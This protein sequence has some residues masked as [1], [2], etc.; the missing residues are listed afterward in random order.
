M[1]HARK[2]NAEVIDLRDLFQIISKRKKLIGIVTLLF[3]VGAGLYSFSA[4]PIYQVQAMIE[5]GKLKAGTK[6]EKAL[7]D[8]EYVKQKLEYIYGVKSKKKREYPI[9]KAIKGSKKAKSIFI[10]VVEGRS[11]KQAVQF[12]EKIVQKIEAEYRTK[13]SR[14]IKTQKDLI[15]LKKM[16]IER[17]NKNL[18]E[19]KKS[20]ENYNKK[21]MNIRTEDAALSGIYTI[22][23]SQNQTQIQD[24]QERI[25][26]LK[27][28]VYDLQLS[29]TTLRIKQTQ[30]VGKVEILDKPV[31][32]KKVLIMV[33]SFITGLLFSIFLVF[34]L[35]FIAIFRRTEKNT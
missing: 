17:S 2:H 3:I 32:P 18:S 10:V 25:S 22:Q 8:I 29:I 24:L 15:A 12:I 35:N 16:D 4:K 14:Y 19:I 28:K 30:I 20:I 7:D 6:D 21:I 34:L 11:N 26:K 33:V 13:V 23:I 31:R 5:I 1:E 9:I 27:S